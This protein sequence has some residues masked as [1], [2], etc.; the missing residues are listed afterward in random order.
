MT[1]TRDFWTMQGKASFDDRNHPLLTTD[2]NVRRE[3]VERIRA[4]KR[5]Y[6]N[7][8]V[9]MV[10]FV[11]GQSA[12]EYLRNPEKMDRWQVRT[13]SDLLGVTLDHLRY[14]CEDPHPPYQDSAVAGRLYDLLSPEHRSVVYQLMCILAGRDNEEHARGGV[15]E[16]EMAASMFGGARRMLDPELHWRNLARTFERLKAMGPTKTACS[17]EELAASGLHGRWGSHEERVLM[18]S[19]SI[20]MGLLVRHDPDWREHAAEAGIGMSARFDDGW[21]D[22][23]GNKVSDPFGGSNE[24]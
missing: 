24:G 12:G 22:A 9:G 20:A 5:G 18:E 15:L 17:E 23:D 8:D 14:G 1:K 6:T 7:A 13:L 16:D 10:W 4:A 21:H 2:E 3:I 11:T 19:A